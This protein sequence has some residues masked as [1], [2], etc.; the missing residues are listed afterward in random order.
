[1]RY[2]VATV[3]LAVAMLAAPTATTT[4]EAGSNPAKAFHHKMVNKGYD[5]Q[6]IKRLRGPSGKVH[7]DCWVKWGQTSRIWCRDGYRATS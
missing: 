6:I 4:A 1:M 2:I 7:R 5:D 3:A